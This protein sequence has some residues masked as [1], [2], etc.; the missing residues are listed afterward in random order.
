MKFTSTIL[1]FAIYASGALLAAADTSAEAACGSLGVMQVDK[2]AL[3]AGV[4]PNDIRQCAEHPAGKLAQP[5]SK[6]DCWHG[7]SSGCSKNYCWKVCGENNS[8]QWC[9]TAFNKGYGKWIGC[10]D[11]SQCNTGMACGI[12]KC[13]SCGCSC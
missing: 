5:L 11:D 8:G 9:W 2:A 4:D 3:P 7:K 13:D 6:R 1:A 12:G 10:S